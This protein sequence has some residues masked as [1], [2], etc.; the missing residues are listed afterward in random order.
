MI[1][2]GMAMV[3]DEESPRKIQDRMNSYL[4]PTI[5]YDIDRQLKRKPDGDKADNKK[6]AGK[7]KAKAN[8][9]TKPKPAKKLAPANA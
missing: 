4:D 5:R 8:D 1:V 6:A 9:Q 7:P 3:A 2:E